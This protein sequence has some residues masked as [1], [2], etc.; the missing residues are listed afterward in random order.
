MLFEIMESTQD[1]SMDMAFTR[2]D[3]IFFMRQLKTSRCH[4][5][6]KNTTKNVR[7]LS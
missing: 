6:T 3:L 7:L 1:T 5:T 2:Q 4:K